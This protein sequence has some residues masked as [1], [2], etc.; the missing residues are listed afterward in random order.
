M[1]VLL[2]KNIKRSKL[3][4]VAN[5]AQLEVLDF[6]DVTEGGLGTTELSAPDAMLFVSSNGSAVEAQSSLAFDGT[7]LSVN[8]NGLVS[9]GSSG[10][11]GIGTGIPTSRLSLVGDLPIGNTSIDRTFECSSVSVA[12]NLDGLKGPSVSNASV[13]GEW[14][15]RTSVYGAWTFDPS[16]PRF[17]QSALGS[18][19]VDALMTEHDV[20]VMIPASLSGYIGLYDVY[21]KAFRD[22]VFVD[23]T[24]SSHVVAGGCMLK[25]GKVLIATKTAYFFVV[26]LS[27]G[28]T[29]TVSATSSVLAIQG[30][31]DAYLSGGT[32]LPDGRVLFAP[33]T[34]QRTCMY[35]PGNNTVQLV[36]PVLPESATVNSQPKKFKSSILLLDGRMCYVPYDSDQILFYNPVNDVVV[37][38]PFPLDNPTLELDPESPNF[39]PVPNTPEKF[40]AGI[41]A[42]NGYLWFIP[43]DVH[44]VVVLNPAD[45]TNT[46]IAVSPTGT[47][48]R[49]CGGILAPDGR[50]VLVPSGHSAVVVLNTVT[51]ARTEISMG[52]QANQKYGGQVFASD[53][54]VV[55]APLGETRVGLVGPYLPAKESDRVLHPFYSAS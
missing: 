52:S 9:N 46:K 40:S 54:T 55:M 29:T 38:V 3:I 39:N 42:P 44:Y 49:F 48:D 23:V 21:R 25:S 34:A 30:Q 6:L 32:L 26:D 20:A 5:V 1:Q 37:N 47:T 17:A 19:Y 7:T 22:P 41:L 53:G 27:T 51:F 50:L 31:A 24:P 13:L 33:G 4:G 45:F 11:V 28:T 10:R 18:G 14:H 36:G 43:K 2:N 16:A 8:G 12:E 35:N 15:A